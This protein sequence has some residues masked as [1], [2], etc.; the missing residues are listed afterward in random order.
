LSPAA[1]DS[2][3]GKVDAKIDAVAATVVVSVR[4]TRVTTDGDDDDDDDDDVE[5]NDDDSRFCGDCGGDVLADAADD[6]A[7]DDDDTDD[8]D[9][10]DTDDDDDDDSDDDDVARYECARRSFDMQ[11]GEPAAADA[12]AASDANSDDDGRNVEATAFKRFQYD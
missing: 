12:N 8:D 5:E 1:D 10:D 11:N 6:D 3:S 2:S 9:A 7:D 4:A